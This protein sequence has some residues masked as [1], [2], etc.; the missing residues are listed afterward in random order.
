MAEGLACSIQ[1]R[2]PESVFAGG[3]DKYG[4]QDPSRAC[5]PDPAGNGLAPD[6]ETA[7]LDY[8]DLWLNPLAQ[9]LL[10]V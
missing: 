8:F 6:G 1:A 2:V 5:G 4:S 9:S 3:P 10:T 7:G